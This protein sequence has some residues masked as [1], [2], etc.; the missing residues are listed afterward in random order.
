MSKGMKNTD[1]A[2]DSDAL[3]P[4]RRRGLPRR[5]FLLGGAAA[6]I[7]LSTWFLGTASKLERAGVKPSERPVD[8]TI[9]AIYSCGT[10]SGGNNCGGLAGCNPWKEVTSGCS[11]HLVSNP[12]SCL[13]HVCGNHLCAT[14]TCNANHCTNVYEGGCNAQNQCD[15]VYSSGGVGWNGSSDEY[16]DQVAEMPFAQSLGRGRAS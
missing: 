16:G 6:T 14:N 8:E 4:T 15:S 10:P 3:E 11:S 7:G 12:G 1:G 9:P 5:E 2:L 13:D